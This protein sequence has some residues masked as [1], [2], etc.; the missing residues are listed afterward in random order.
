MFILTSGNSLIV[1]TFLIV[2]RVQK[3]KGFVP[4]WN[5]L[6]ASIGPPMDCGSLHQTLFFKEVLEIQLSVRAD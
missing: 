5:A 6:Q 3:K 2:I 4:Y 1:F